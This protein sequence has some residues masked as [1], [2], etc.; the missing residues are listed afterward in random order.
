[1]RGWIAAGAVVAAEVVLYWQYAELDGEFHYWLHGLFGAALG[2]AVSTAARLIARRRWTVTRTTGWRL[3]P[4][5]AALLGHLYSAFPDVMFLVADVPHHR[6]MD[7]FAFHITAHFVPA[8]IPTVL[9]V[10]LLA[11]AG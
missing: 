9:V 6:W 1:M 8:A 2:V 3:T 11:L 10:F 4:W 5:E 7:V